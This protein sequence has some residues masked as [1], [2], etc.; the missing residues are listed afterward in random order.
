MISGS[1]REETMS[2]SHVERLNLTMRHTVGRTRRLCLAFSKTMRGHHAAMA[3]GVIA[4]NFTTVH[5]AIETT[6]AMFA[7]LTDHMWTMGEL[8]TAALDAESQ[9]R[10]PSP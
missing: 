8:V 2:T 1:P 5:S 6:P 4:D 7:K 10:I 9:S 3:L